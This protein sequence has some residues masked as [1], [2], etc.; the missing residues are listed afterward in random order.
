MYWNCMLHTFEG[1]SLG[2]FNFIVNS[3]CFKI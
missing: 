3:V 2:L 1:G